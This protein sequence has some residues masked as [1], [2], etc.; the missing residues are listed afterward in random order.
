MG[1]GNFKIMLIN[2]TNK[3]SNCNAGKKVQGFRNK[4]PI[5]RQQKDESTVM[6]TTQKY[7][8]GSMNSCFQKAELEIVEFLSLKTEPRVAITGEKIKY[9]AWDKPART[10]ITWYPLHSRTVWCVY[11]KWTNRFFLQ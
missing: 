6:N 11:L 9:K 4:Y 1:P 3:M 10:Y 7:F 8:S 5:C 2:G